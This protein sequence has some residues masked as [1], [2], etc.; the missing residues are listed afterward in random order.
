M[1]PR[2]S[3]YTKENL[4]RVIEKGSNKIVYM[5]DTGR[6]LKSYKSVVAH[7]DN[8]G[9]VTLGPHW[10]YSNTTMKQVFAFIGTRASETRKHIDSGLYSYNGEM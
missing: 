2:G 5:D 9:H 4:M 10:D 8:S 7:I 3:Q 1:T 6:Y